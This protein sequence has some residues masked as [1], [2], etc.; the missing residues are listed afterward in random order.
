[1][2]M[3]RD[4]TKEIVYGKKA[5]EAPA[6][7]GIETYVGRFKVRVPV[8]T[9]VPT[10]GP[11]MKAMRAYLNTKK[12]LTLVKT[13]GTVGLYSDR[14]YTGLDELIRCK[15]NQPAYIEITHICYVER[16]KTTQRVVYV[17][18]EIEPLPV[19]HI[20]HFDIP[21]PRVALYYISIGDRK[22]ARRGVE[23]AEWGFREDLSGMPGVKYGAIKRGD[24]IAL[25]GTEIRLFK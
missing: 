20:L 2:G 23:V 22:R 1:M 5:V 6:T 19:G 18:R 9:R 15:L 11:P 12:A 3:L 14:F 25:V 24:K 7:R 8:V 13:I 16:L 4:L 17:G 10:E 21:G